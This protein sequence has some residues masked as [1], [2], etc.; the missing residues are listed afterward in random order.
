MSEE[1]AKDSQPAVIYCPVCDRAYRQEDHDNRAYQFMIRHVKL[2]H[3]EYQN[4][5]E[6]DV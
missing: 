3:P 1:E 5:E 2:Q 6:W 4:I